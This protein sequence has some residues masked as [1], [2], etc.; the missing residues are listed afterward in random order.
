MQHAQAELN[1]INTQIR[2]RTHEVKAMESLLAEARTQFAQFVDRA[3][4]L[5]VVEGGRLDTVKAILSLQGELTQL[6][7]QNADLRSRIA[8]DKQDGARRSKANE[9]KDEAHQAAVNWVTEKD[10]LKAE[11]AQLTQAIQE[12]KLSVKS[13]DSK[14]TARQNSFDAVLPLLKKWQGSGEVEVPPDATVAGLIQEWQEAKA[15]HDRRFKA[16]QDE[17]ARLISENSQLE[18]K[19]GKRK[20]ALDRSVDQFHALETQML[21]SIE[22]LK[23]QA[24]A[25]EQKLQ[26]QIAKAKLNIGQNRIQKV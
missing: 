26:K 7:S 5:D 13:R 2:E 1:Y 8:D 18:D 16:D 9:K 14:L 21:K 15:D 12:K 20:A 23:Q 25:Q 4:Q 22:E 6:E 10:D 11:L 17:I 19:V 24:D 3:Q